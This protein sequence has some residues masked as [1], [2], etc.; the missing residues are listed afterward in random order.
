VNT[1]DRAGLYTDRDVNGDGGLGADAG[2]WLPRTFIDPSQVYWSS[3]SLRIGWRPG[4]LTDHYQSLARGTSTQGEPP[5][6]A[7]VEIGLTAPLGS[8]KG[9]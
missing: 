3:D 9:S 4:T 2:G 1:P 7:E 6:G 5:S 8:T